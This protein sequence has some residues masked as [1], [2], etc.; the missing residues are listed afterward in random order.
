MAPI[1]D[2]MRLGLLLQL[3]YILKAKNIFTTETQRAQSFILL[4]TPAE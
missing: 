2:W 3:R 1:Y 4:T